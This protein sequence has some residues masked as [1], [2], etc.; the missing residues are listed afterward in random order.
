MR[1]KPGPERGISAFDTGRAPYQLLLEDGEDTGK[2]WGTV[3]A[4]SHSPDYLVVSLPAGWD[5]RAREPSASAA[6]VGWCGEMQTNIE[7]GRA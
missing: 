5:G 3:F 6:A 2:G 1:D 7:V 4:L